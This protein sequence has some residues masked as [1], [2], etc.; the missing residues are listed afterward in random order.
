MNKSFYHLLFT[1]PFYSFDSPSYSPS[2]LPLFESPSSHPQL[3]VEQNIHPVSAWMLEAAAAAR[4]ELRR[5]DQGQYEESWS[6][7]DALLQKIT[8]KEEWVSLLK[9]MRQPFGKVN[10]RALKRETPAYDP[11]GL[12][13]GEYM[14]IEYLTSFDKGAQREERLTLRR[15]SEGRWR[16]LTYRLY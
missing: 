2:S 15:G 11:K 14:I 13:E 8:S 12:P 10:Q 7:G 9:E 3:A 4:E 6:K 16:V 1:L 5:I